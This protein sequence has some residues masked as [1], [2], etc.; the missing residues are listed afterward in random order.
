MNSKKLA[1]RPRGPAEASF[2]DDELTLVD[3]IA[4][5]PMREMMTADA[6][7]RERRAARCATGGGWAPRSR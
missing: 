6:P 1:P 3:A 2:D 5:L 4:R 7:S